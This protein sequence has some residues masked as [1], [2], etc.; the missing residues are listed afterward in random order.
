MSP[1]L[2]HL[3][4]PLYVNVYGLFIAL[5][6]G[7][8]IYLA[9]QDKQLFKA[10]DQESFFSFIVYTIIAAIAG[11]RLLFA[12]ENWHDL[13][14]VGFIF[15]FW[16]P[17]YSILGA[18]TLATL[19]GF[20]YLKKQ[21][22]APAVVLDRV[23]LYIPLIQSIARIGCYFAGCCYGIATTVPWAVVYTHPKNLAPLYSAVHP[24]QLYSSLLLF[25]LFISL[26]YF[27]KLFSKKGQLLSLYLIGAGFERFIVDFLR[28]D[29]TL[30][31]GNISATQLVAV[32][33]VSI[34][35]ILFCKAS[36][37][38]RK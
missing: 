24:T 16:Q 11:G 3:A 18:I 4:G 38:K 23:A 30:V 1:Q 31:I 20:W 9:L 25:C 7:I 17:G 26:Y 33:I 21:S 8:G 37:A 32:A 28:A 5:G 27:Q 22:I 36:Y 15:Q 10:I 35:L 14:S 29:R 19:C 13:S 34:G 2:L 12:L 6:T